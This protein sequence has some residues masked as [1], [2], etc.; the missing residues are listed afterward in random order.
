ML[1]PQGELWVRLHD[2]PRLPRIQQAQADRV[3]PHAHEAARAVDGIQH[4]VPPL[5]ASRQACALM[6]LLSV[7]DRLGAEAG[8]RVTCCGSLPPPRDLQGRA[9]FQRAAAKVKAV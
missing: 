5:Q 8:S 4:P 3:L 1:A 2:G 9:R 7:Q 6:P